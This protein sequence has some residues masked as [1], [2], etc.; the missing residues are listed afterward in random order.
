MIFNFIVIRNSTINY[1]FKV[2]EEVNE[3]EFKIQ[4]TMNKDDSNE[5]QFPKIYYGNRKNMFAQVYTKL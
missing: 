1:Y 5:L 4:L 2:L 3:I